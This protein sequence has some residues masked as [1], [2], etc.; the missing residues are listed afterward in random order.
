MKL[1][2]IGRV[3]GRIVFFQSGSGFD[4]LV[5]FETLVQPAV[6]ESKIPRPSAGRGLWWSDLRS[7]PQNR[8][9]PKAYGLR[10][11]RES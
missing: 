1:D 10:I 8:H 3:P 6:R 5:L 2:A 7:A 11:L 4:G 9:G